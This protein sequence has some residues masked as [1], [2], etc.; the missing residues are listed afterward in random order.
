M[1]TYFL[2]IPINGPKS[3]F[4]VLKFVFCILQYYKTTRF[5]KFRS[6]YI[7]IA[8]YSSHSR[9]HCPTSSLLICSLQH[10]ENAN[11]KIPIS[12]QQTWVAVGRWQVS[13]GSPGFPK[14]LRVYSKRQAGWSTW[15]S[16]RKFQ[17]PLVVVLIA[18]YG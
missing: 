6:I 15:K 1:N 3:M 8:M 10:I 17:V 13:N 7:Y 16:F 9:M 5:H 14:G 4:S 12:N 11:F 18:R 2:S